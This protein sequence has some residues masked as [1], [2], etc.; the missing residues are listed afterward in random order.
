VARPG[1]W[2]VGV[3]RVA[4]VKAPGGRLD[5]VLA[6]YVGLAEDRVPVGGG[7]GPVD[8][9]LDPDEPPG[10]WRG[11]GRHALELEGPVAGENLRALLDGHHPHT[12]E[13][14]GRRF[15]E[16][17]ARGFD[18][19]FS[20]PKSVSV[21]W[22]LTPDPWVRAE[23]LAAHDAAVDAALDWF[24][25]HGGV[26]RRGRDGILQV[27]TRGFTAAVFR[28]HTS[29]TVD[30]QL[31]THAVISSKV[32]DDTGTWLALDARF[33]KYQQRTIGWIYDAALRAEMTTRLGVEW[34][35]REAAVFDLTCVP[36][37]VRD[38]FSERSTQ[39]DAKFAELVRRWA[40]DHDG[41][42]P[43][44]RTLA[45]LQRAAA[46]ASRPGK[47]QGLDPVEMHA[48]WAA[49]A[50]VAGFNPDRLTADQIT[51][52]SGRI[53]D[54]S[55]D[56]VIEKALRRVAE[57]SATW[58]RAD[59]ARHLATI[60]P[61]DTAPGA[62]DLVAEIDRRAAV[63]EQRCLPVGP[64]RDS[65]IRR[66]RDGR[67]VL[68]HVTD[69][70]LTL[71]AVLAEERRLQDWATTA[72]T[73]VTPTADPQLAAAEAIAGSARLV[74]VVGPAGT[75]KTHTIARAADGLRSQRRPVVG[76]APSGKAADVLA[77]EARCPTDTLAGFLTRHRNAAS[78]WPGGT[79]VILD[80]AGMAASA[81]LARL[82]DLVE[83]NRW[84]L[85]VVGDPEQLPAVGRGGVFAH[86][87]DTLDHHTLDTPRRFAQP[88]EAAASLALRA[89]HSD[90]A[91]AYAEHGRLHT[92]HP[93]TLAGQIAQAHRHHA[94]AGRTVAITTTNADTA[95]AINREIQWHTHPRASGGVPL[96]DGTSAMVGDQIATRRNDR[97]LVTNHG[98][99][100]RNR[101]TW[102]VTATRPD[103]SLTVSHPDRGTAEL[104]TDY[105]REHVELGWAVT[106]YGNQGDTVDV[107]IAVL[108]AGTSRN[109][110]YVAMTRGRHAN[111]ALV[112]D[113]TGT[114]DPA[115]RLAE[116]IARPTTAESALATQ[117]RLHRQAGNEPPT[118]HAPASTQSQPHREPSA[119]PAIDPELERQRQAMQRRL[120][121]LQQRPASR[122]PDRS[123]G[124]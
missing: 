31:H 75:G 6:Y 4:T 115:D 72:T 96:H 80:E 36:E 100:V 15:G 116:I 52:I 108:D 58:L 82:V 16:S 71:P 30:P 120:D 11:H 9:Y 53:V 25:H 37:P 12:G 38:A 57:E 123:L 87:C 22:A 61:H 112:V 104:P 101:H 78:P 77:L 5:A 21:L 34:V 7:R 48:H 62:G 13:R 35:E 90:A 69:R 86:W 2:L 95:R 92:A 33:R 50:R 46:V 8:Y 18:A 124:L 93:A 68:E 19:T 63:A 74:I 14:L 20:A 102:T 64:E 109:H 106:G 98:Q 47:V 10:Q 40:A 105:V 28:Q 3:M 118:A 67:P 59:L 81:D 56:D 122:G 1:G 45:R 54:P 73:L 44:P 32:Q 94:G 113:P 84:R 55:D 103:G 107:G 26:T 88:W 41:A 70:R 83:E 17:S 42:D 39:V 97:H 27:D 85:V 89:G 66:R 114:I 24:E 79:T 111:H 51:H 23:V 91:T 121:Q 99:Q 76:L 49:E 117:A 43:D 60:L 29:R 65:A 119:S 110:A